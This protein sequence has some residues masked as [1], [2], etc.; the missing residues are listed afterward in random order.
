MEHGP[1]V[2]REGK[3]VGDFQALY[4]ALDPS[5]GIDPVERP[6][7]LRLLEAAVIH[8]AD[9]EGAVGTDLAVVE[10]GVIAVPF[11]RR[12]HGLSLA[13]RVED[14]HLM[15][16]GDDQASGLAKSER[17][18]LAGKRPVATFPPREINPVQ[19][20]AGDGAKTHGVANIRV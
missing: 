13:V 2:G 4:F 6:D 7:R 19:G 20:A 18:D 14:D 11:D 8:A 12:D 16:E 3:P 10:P 15:A 5:A 1:A 17:A 9:P